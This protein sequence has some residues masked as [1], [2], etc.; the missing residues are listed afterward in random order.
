MRVYDKQPPFLQLPG[1]RI[2]KF[3][4]ADK[5]SSPVDPHYFRGPVACPS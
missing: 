3:M 1:L 2:P 5:Q 4:M